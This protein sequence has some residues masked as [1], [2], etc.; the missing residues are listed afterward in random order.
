MTSR[1]SSKLINMKNSLD[2]VA[3]LQRYFNAKVIGSQ[4]FV[5]AGLLSSSETNDIDIAVVNKSDQ[6]SSIHKFLTDQGFKYEDI[7]VSPD[8]YGQVL[9]RTKYTNEEYDKVID[10][11]YFDKMPET[12]SISQLVRA[13]FEQGRKHDLHQLFE[14]ILKKGGSDLQELETLYQQYKENQNTESSE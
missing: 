10:L 9:S 13:K 7:M 4:L 11:N 2:I 3:Q 8:G 14:V 12:Y 6:K 1:N 5:S